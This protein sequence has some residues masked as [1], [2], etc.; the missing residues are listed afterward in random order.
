MRLTGSEGIQKAK[1]A[2]LTMVRH[3][4]EH[5]V[6]ADA[7]MDS[8]DEEITL[9]MAHEAVWRQDADGRL[10][11][12]Y[13]ARNITDPCTCGESVMY[14][15]R[16][17]GDEYYRNAADKML[18]YIEQAPSGHRGLQLHNEDQPMIAADCSYMIAPFFAVM[19]R[20]DEAIRQL[21][22][23]INLLWDGQNRLLRHQWNVETGDWWSD[24]FWGAATGWN[25][26]AI[27]R[28][29]HLLPESMAEGRRLLADHLTRIISGIL[30]Y[31]LENGLFYDVLDDGENSFVETNCAQ[32]IAYSIYQ[33]VLDGYLDEKYIPAASRMRKAAN[34]KLDAQGFV[35]DVSAAPSFTFP[36]VSPEGQAFYILMETAACAFEKG[37]AFA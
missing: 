33:G 24:K 26:A 34:Q 27:V 15:Y 4:W 19:G 1:L 36:G 23:R 35:R 17:T 16:K 6:A 14:A 8:G 28:V 7:F 9:L 13:R 29:M 31:Q 5:G 37:R 10:S 30:D 22:E 18:A 20:Y 3:P 12:T 25:A 21:D 32:M 2:L 11:M